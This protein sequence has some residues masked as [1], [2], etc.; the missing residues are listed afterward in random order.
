MA[1][2]QMELCTEAIDTG[3]VNLEK[4]E[5]LLKYKTHLKHL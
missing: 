2:L 1:Q 5:Q 4:R 3:K